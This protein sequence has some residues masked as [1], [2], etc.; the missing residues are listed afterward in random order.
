MA[1]STG[2]GLP[3]DWIEVTAKE[4]RVSPNENGFS[5]LV[6]LSSYLTWM[7]FIK[8]C[9]FRM[10]CAVNFSIKVLS[11]G[12]LSIIIEIYILVKSQNCWA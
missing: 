7:S 6:T 5:G 8:I 4:S 11:A 1:G 2:T 3:Q 9:T 10:I 12:G